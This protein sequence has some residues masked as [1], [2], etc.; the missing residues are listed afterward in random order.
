[1]RT[2]ISSISAITIIL[3]LAA[4]TAGDDG[5][6]ATDTTTT[7]PTTSSTTAVDTETTGTTDSTT[8]PTTSTTDPTTTTTTDTDTGV[9]DPYVFDDADPMSLAQVD[10]M[11][12]PAI[13]T[14]VIT[15]KDDYNKATPAD[16]ANGDF[17]PEIGA[18]VT[19]LHA[20]LDDDFMG[21]GLTPCAVDTCIAQAAPL[22][23]PDTLK[24]N[25]AADAGFPNGRMLAD[26]VIDITLA[27]VFL[28]LS[29][30][31]QTAATLAGVPVNPPE[32]D[33]AFSAAFPYLADPH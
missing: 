8:D 33:K 14:V 6:S 25:T 1:M 18:N 24:I 21:L 13:N 30:P 3:S 28:D 17:V 16:D 29:V 22:V 32:N 23:V 5:G 11:G 27:V 19:A 12:M 7:T 15:S 10:R 26:Q 4:C 9:E 31:G 20:A 2:I